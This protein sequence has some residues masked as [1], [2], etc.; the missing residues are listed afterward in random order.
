MAFGHFLLGSN[1]SV[2]MAL[3]LVCEVALSFSVNRLHHKCLPWP[4]SSLVSFAWATLISMLI[5]PLNI[6]WELLVF[7]LGDPHLLV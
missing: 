4:H 7:L 6:K 3:W 1:N 5:N 2:V